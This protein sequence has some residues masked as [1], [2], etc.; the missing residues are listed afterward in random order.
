MTAANKRA[1]ALEAENEHLRADVEEWRSKYQK[2]MG[3][4]SRTLADLQHELTKLRETQTY[5][6][7]AF[8]IWKWTMT[9]SRMP[10]A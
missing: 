2:S 5:T 6:K 4:H 1:E 10:S 7:R 8:A 9:H 3:E